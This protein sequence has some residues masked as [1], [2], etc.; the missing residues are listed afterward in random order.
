M[1][2]A[3]VANFAHCIFSTKDRQNLISSELQLQLYAY[4]IG[5]GRNLQIQLIAVGGTP[6]HIHLLIAASYGAVRRYPK[7]EGEFLGMDGA[8]GVEL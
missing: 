5:I 2:H 8:A 4:L 1:T 7:M 6:N 3:P